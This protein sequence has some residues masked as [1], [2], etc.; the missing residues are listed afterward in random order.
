EPY[1]TRTGRVVY[2]NRGIQPDILVNP[3]ELSDYGAAL[4]SERILFDWTQELADRIGQP[5]MPFEQFLEKWEP[6]QAQLRDLFAYAKERDLEYDKE[7]WEQ[8]K[9]YLIEQI[10]AEVA[11]RLYN[12]RNYLWEVLINSDATVD[13]A[14]VNMSRSDSLARAETLESLRRSG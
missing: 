12:G 1:Y 4:L 7:G 3:G 5:T 6:S 8:D 2:A 13:S 11:Q 9:G 14:L 10:R